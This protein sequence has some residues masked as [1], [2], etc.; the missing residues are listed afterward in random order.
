MTSRNRV[1]R[2]LR[3]LDTDRPPVAVW[4][5]FAS[6]HLSPAE[7]AEL[8]LRY[9]RAY[10]WDFVKVMHDY[11]WPLFPDGD[12]ASGEALRATRPLTL[13]APALAAQLELVRRV[14]DGVDPDVPVIETL[15]DPLQTLVRSSGRSVLALARAEPEASLAALDA[16]Q[17]TLLTYL[18]A[19]RQAGVD[20]VFYSINGA[21]GPGHGGLERHEFDRLAAPY[22]R[23]ILEAASGM[24]R[25]GHVHG[26]G[27]D[28]ERVL[29]YPVEAFNWSHLHGAPSLAEARELTERALIGG[30]DEIDFASQTLGEAEL[31]I[32]RAVAEAGRS[33][34]LI[35]P[36]C[37]VPPDTPAR[38]LHGVR[39]L[40]EGLG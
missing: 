9:Q 13:E 17:E 6:E 16:V 21:V 2:T 23:A 27:L 26:F 4:L 35:G 36:G 20:G 15:F 24:I 22:D 40:V 19:L 1:D 28:F 31:G 11:R 30:I 14:R 7:A 8:H 5:H 39:Q 33:G 12:P 3:G 10:G 38:L 34:L 37:T 32:R 18:E 29:A 25:I